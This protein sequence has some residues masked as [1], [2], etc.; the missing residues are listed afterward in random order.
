MLLS[1]S[2]R[3]IGALGF[4]AV[5]SIAAS[6]KTSVYTIPGEA[7]A[8]VTSSPGNVTFRLTDLF[9]NPMELMDD[10]SG[11]FGGFGTTPD[12]TQSPSVR[13]PLLQI[14][15]EGSLRM[16]AGSHA[17]A[18]C[19]FFPPRAVEEMSGGLHGP[20]VRPL[21]EARDE[22]VSAKPSPFTGD[23]HIALLDRTATWTL[24]EV[25]GASFHR[26]GSVKFQF[27]TTD[28]Q[29]QVAAAVPVRREPSIPGM[30]GAVAF[31]VL[32]G[33]VIWWKS[34][35]S[36]E[37]IVLRED[38]TRGYGEWVGLN[39]LFRILKHAKFSSGN[40]PGPFPNVAVSAPPPFRHGD[41]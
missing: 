37:A 36:A 29:D 3:F 8:V 14:R 25:G 41:A 19:R 2:V 20:Q 33:L 31:I 16:D 28:G 32:A 13:R 30:L 12:V 40:H 6:A 15:V 24:A 4:I 9:T 18:Y 22:S 35:R 38:G 21:F 27:G 5:F 11:F 34:P 1:V 26:I 10:L 23:T 7:S 17:G 39:R